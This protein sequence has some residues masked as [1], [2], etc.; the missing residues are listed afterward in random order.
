MKSLP[1]ELMHVGRWGWQEN[2]VGVAQGWKGVSKTP[3]LTVF[4]R[5]KLH[6][7]R[8]QRQE[9]IPE[10]F[11]LKDQSE[12]LTDVVETGG[13]AKLHAGYT[14]TLSPGLSLANEH[15]ATGPG[16]AGALLESTN[17]IDSGVYLLGCAHVMALTSADFGQAAQG[18][19][20][21]Q[22]FDPQSNPAT[23]R[24]ATL[25]NQFSNLIDRQIQTDDFAIAKILSGV[26]WDRRLRNTADVAIN[27]KFS[28]NS[29]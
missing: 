13:H 25:T 28:A 14:G 22:P 12:M 6:Q 23:L 26:H 20:I 1:R 9:V 16:S 3:C 8:L 21:E 29:R 10:G 4:V 15:V 24:V 19:F 18:Q 2:I 5:H 17:P 27:I 11:L 7:E